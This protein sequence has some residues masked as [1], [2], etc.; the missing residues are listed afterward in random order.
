MRMD[1]NKLL[2]MSLVLV[3]FHQVMALEALDDNTLSSTTG[4]D[5]INVGLTL[6]KVDIGQVAL[7]DK[8]GIGTKILDQDY[9]KAAS[10]TLAG[11][12]NSP[13]SVN[14]VGANTTPTINAVI[15]TDAGNGKAFANIGLSF[16]NHISALKVS[17]FSVYLSNTNAGKGLGVSKDVFTGTGL[18]AGVTKFIEVGSASNNFEIN[19]VQGNSPRMNVQ[20]GNV[21]QSQ[22]IQFSGAIQSICGTGSGCPIAVI[23]GDTSAKFDFQMKGSTASGISLNGFYA[24][25]EPTGFVFGNNGA[26]SKMD[27]AL[28][29]VMLGN[30]DA[31][32]AP[33]FNGLPNGSM[34]NFGAIGVS[35]KDLKVNIKGL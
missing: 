27:V 30:K 19:F 8:D 31:I 16:G 9:S 25:I 3:P 22:M 32:S 21:P 6:N 11:Q 26:S 15:D 17:P 18:S 14:F 29:N 1:K 4:Q 33:I 34:G 35:V 24:G 2:L 23:S 13:V 7:I 20:L 10:L 28:N 12:T 5:G